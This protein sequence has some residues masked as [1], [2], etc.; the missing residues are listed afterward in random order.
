MSSS[1]SGQHGHSSSR[2]SWWFCKIRLVKGTLNGGVVKNEEG[3]PIQGAWVAYN[4]REGGYFDDGHVTDENGRWNFVDVRPGKDVFIRVTH[5]DYLRLTTLAEMQKAQRDPTAMLLWLRTATIVMHRGVRIAGKV[6]DPQGEPVKRAIL[7]SGDDP[8]FGS[9]TPPVVTDEQ[10]Q[11]QFPMLPAKHGPADRDR[12]RLDARD[13]A[14][15]ARARHGSGRLS[16]EAGKETADSIRRPRRKADP[17]R[18][19]V[20]RTVEQRATLD[21]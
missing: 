8:Y 2:C 18:E 16:L 11:F 7:L 1:I 9:V 15:S 12:Q 14:N 13:A 19:C 4:Y 20:N 10:G 21:H 3:Q 6:V 17:G 5:P